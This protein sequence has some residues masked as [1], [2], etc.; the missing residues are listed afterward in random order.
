MFVYKT[1][2]P[3]ERKAERRRMLD[4]ILSAE[5]TAAGDRVLGMAAP[6]HAKPVALRRQTPLRRTAPLRT[7]SPLRGM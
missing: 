7:A 5:I 3:T 6:R 4:M 2:D 1:D